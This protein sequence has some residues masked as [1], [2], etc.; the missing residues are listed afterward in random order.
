MSAP[1]AN[2][3]PAWFLAQHACGQTPGQTQAA[4]TADKE[5]ALL[6]RCVEAFAS[7]EASKEES[8]SGSA[9]GTPTHS[10][11]TIEQALVVKASTGFRRP[12]LTISSEEDQPASSLLGESFRTIKMLHHMRLLR[13][14]PYKA[15]ARFSHSGERSGGRGW[16]FN[17]GVVI[18]PTPPPC[19]TEASSAS[20]LFPP[21]RPHP[22]LQPPRQQQSV[23]DRG[24]Q[25]PR[26]RPRVPG[27]KITP[28]A[29]QPRPRHD[30]R[31]YDARLGS[32]DDDSSCTNVSA[33]LVPR[34][35]PKTRTRPSPLCLQGDTE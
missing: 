33:P 18:E 26:L 24:H 21:L 6:T 30:K 20:L 15:S 10:P 27:G 1:V 29:C 31:R 25:L 4:Y 16:K 8:P 13:Q 12:W 32:S 23:A 7:K 35:G 19:G 5:K 14:E 22:T 17:S 34:A 2:L 3:V 9:S 28:A 11:V